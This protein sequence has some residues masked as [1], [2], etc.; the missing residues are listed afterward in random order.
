MRHPK[1]FS[2][3]QSPEQ[4]AALDPSSPGEGRCLHLS[5]QPDKRFVAPVYSIKHMSYLIYYQVIG[6][7]TLHY[8][9]PPLVR[10]FISSATYY[11]M[12]QDGAM[13]EWFSSFS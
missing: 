7:L 12:L 2:P 6:Y 5:V 11:T 1:H 9:P 10:R 8:R 4:I 13:Q 3:L